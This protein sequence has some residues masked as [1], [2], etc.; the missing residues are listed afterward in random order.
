MS[1][2]FSKGKAS[3]SEQIIDLEKLYSL[4][5]RWC[6]ESRKF[7]KSD[8]DFWKYLKNKTSDLEVRPEFKDCSRPRGFKIPTHHIPTYEKV[9]TEV[10]E[11]TEHSLNRIYNKNT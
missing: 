6:N 4:Y 11:T 8:T 9:I 5:R 1:F 2:S 7:A 3:G 10:T